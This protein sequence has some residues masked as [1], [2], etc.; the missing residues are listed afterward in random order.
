MVYQEKAS[1]TYTGGKQLL[2]SEDT[3]ARV[4]EKFGKSLEE[5]VRRQT[6][7][8]SLVSSTR[9]SVRLPGRNF[10]FVKPWSGKTITL[11]IEPSVT[12]TVHSVK[13]EIKDKLGVPLDKQNL[14][15]NGKRL[16]DDRALSDYNIPMESVLHLVPAMQIFVKVTVT[17][18]IISLETEPND[19][20]DSIKKKIQDKEGVPA[21]YQRLFLAGKQLEDRYTLSNYNIQE[22]STLHLVLKF[23]RIMPI[24]IKT[25]TGITIT[26]E[27]EPNDTIDSIKKKIQDK[28]GV[29]AKYQRLFLAGKQLEDR[30]TLSNY[31]IQEEST[32]HLVLKFSRIMP[33]FIKTPTGI[34]ITLETEPNDTIDSIKKKIQDKEG[35]PAKYQRLFLA[36]KQLEDRYTLSNYNIQEESTLH[37]VLKFSRIMLIFIK[38]LTG[39][40]IFL[41]TE[42][43]D[44]IKDVKVKIQDKEGIPTNQQ[45]LISVVKQL[46]LQDQYTLRYYNIQ[47]EATLHLVFRSVY[48]N[49]P[50][51]IKILTGKTITL[52]YEPS[53]T[54]ED[55]KVKIQD[56]EGIPT[57]QQRLIFVGK[58]LQDQYTLS[59]YNIQEEATLHLVLRLPN[60]FES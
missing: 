25:P 37:L 45:R 10:I 14:Q 18:K 21:K 55:V 59:Y 7:C 9:S 24:F 33:I 26:L 39:K 31:N 48:W 13:V 8:D 12:V 42:P 52:E 41:E 11:E 49:R 57:D 56:K 1:A 6:T 22:E 23:S 44:T 16:E 58:L 35:V 28:E 2:R 50:I 27:T 19:T 36:G 47:N 54:I 15:F 40:T 53:D 51:F 32:L 43:S 30:Y 34:T 4:D 5:K 29:P 3:E 17:G 60:N 20:I 38:T 46:Q